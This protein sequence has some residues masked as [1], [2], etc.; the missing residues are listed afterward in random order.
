MKIYK[1]SI[2]IRNLIIHGVLSILYLHTI[3]SISNGRTAVD[4]KYL[5]ESL[6]SHPYLILF[7][8]LTIFLINRVSRHSPKFFIIFCLFVFISSI[9]IFFATFNKFILSLNFVYIATSFIS[10]ILLKSELKESIYIPGFHKNEISKLSEY[11]LDVEI[12]DSSGNHFSGYLTNWG[13]NGCFLVLNKFRQLKGFVNLSFSFGEKEFNC[14]G[15]IMTMYG[16]GFGISIINEKRKKD[17]LNLGWSE[18]Y[19]II[20]QRGYVPRHQ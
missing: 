6:L 8:L 20:N 17:L 12:E 3:E 11:N 2:I 10:Y 4:I 13:Q 1:R 16:S 18:Y 19:D 15:R 9:E 5:N 14:V 7:L